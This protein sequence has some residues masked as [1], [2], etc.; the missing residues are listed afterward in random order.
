C[1]KCLHAE[2]GENAV[3][4]ETD[5]ERVRVGP[6]VSLG[7]GFRVVACD[8]P[9][10]EPASPSTWCAFCRCVCKVCGG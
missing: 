5:R 3:F 10:R 9:Q 6:G 2:G 1:G 8:C 4:V 7:P